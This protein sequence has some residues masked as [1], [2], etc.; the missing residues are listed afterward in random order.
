MDIWP[1]PPTRRIIILKGQLLRRHQHQCQWQVCGVYSL[2]SGLNL[3][4]Q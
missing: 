4:V 3:Q 2:T 1:F